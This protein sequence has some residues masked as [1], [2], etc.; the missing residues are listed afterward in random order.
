M[1][2]HPRPLFP[3]HEAEKKIKIIKI[4]WGILGLV[5]G[6]D[7]FK[8]TD[9][10]V[11]PASPLESA[12]LPPKAMYGLPALLSYLAVASTAASIR[13]LFTAEDAARSHQQH[14]IRRTLDQ[15]LAPG[16]LKHY[17]AGGLIGALAP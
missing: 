3:L 15:I 11:Q 10:M 5:G 8:H 12:Y 16:L 9:D 1:G 14:G 4:N 2:A 13:L 17:K 6:V 7:S